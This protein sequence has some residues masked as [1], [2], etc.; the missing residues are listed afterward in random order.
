VQISI[1][2]GEI[3]VDQLA[4]HFIDCLKCFKFVLL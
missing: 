4:F 1:Y 2:I 3:P